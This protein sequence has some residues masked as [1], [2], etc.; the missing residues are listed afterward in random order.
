MTNPQ[1]VRDAETGS[2]SLPSTIQ[3]CHPMTFLKFLKQNDDEI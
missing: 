1:V 2:Q 3:H